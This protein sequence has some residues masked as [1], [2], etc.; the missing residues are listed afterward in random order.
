MYISQDKLTTDVHWQ[1]GVN[2][3]DCHGGNPSVFDPAKLHAA[4]DGFRRLEDVKDACRDCHAD[5]A[6][7]LI[8]GVHAKAGPRDDRGRGTP[9]EC[10][11]CHGEVAHG[12]LPV[13]DGRSPVFLDNQVQTCGG[14]HPEDVT[15][16][17][18]T[19]HGQGL[20]QSGLLVTAVCADCHGAHGI[21]YAADRRSTLH[22]AKVAATCGECH[23][24]IEERLLASVHGRGAGPG[25]VAERPAPG[26]Q[27]ACKPSCS[28][29]HQGHHLLQ[30]DSDLFHQ[31][32]ASRC[33]NCHPD[34]SSRYA[35]STHGELTQL[36]YAPAANCADCHG[37][38]D[39]LPVSDPKSPLA[40]GKNRLATC[41]NCHIYATANFSDFDPHANYKDPARYP[42]LSSVYHGAH[43]LIYSMFGLFLIHAF[44]WFTRSFVHTL[45]HGRHKTLVTQQAALVRIEPIH[46]LLG[47]LL[48]VAF[49]GLTLT[50]LPLK[51]G[52]QEW[53]RSLAR[54]LGGFGSSSMWH[55]F[56]AIL[57]I[58][59][60]I[61]H[62]VWGAG[63]IIRLGGEGMAWRAILF[64]PDSPVPGRRD[65]KDL[66]GML[67]WFLGI[68]RRPV[69]ERW[70]YWEK[71]DY[72]GLYLVAIPVGLSGL[73]LWYPNL[74]C[75]VLPGNALNVAKVIHSHVAILAASLLFVIYFFHTHFRPE[76][77]P[78]DLS[79]VTGVVSEEHLRK[80][81]PEYVERLHRAGKLQERRRTAPSE[82][83]LWLTL[84]AGLVVFSLALWLLALI[85]LASL[86]E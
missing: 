46:R 6:V 17:K 42:L 34:L 48:I 44:L 39:I 74:F 77:F 62:L 13:K 43:S 9:L 23:A 50:G 32:L 72:W 27:T 60:G 5:Q 65:V 55:H 63:R 64:G 80:Y 33:G 3:S 73:M 76:K 85:L 54:G 41:R 1:K 21:Y 26:G 19:V 52:N 83:R 66:L 11:K 12:L 15:T 7:D 37:S 47:G 16:Y 35:M 71:L 24:F 75:L 58:F 4:E 10:G 8:K 14:C 45:R 38:H 20:Y 68:G 67:R 57:A 36:G 79:A 30:P 84:L 29:C 18:T 31:Q 22:A 78:L 28:S 59:T 56:F 82:R 70:T 86:G 51:Y 81:R 40:R 25:E 53:A 2:C 49:L 61:T 69:F